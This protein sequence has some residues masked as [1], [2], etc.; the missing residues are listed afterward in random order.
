METGFRTRCV[1]SFMKRAVHRG[2]AQ[3]GRRWRP[4]D[5]TAAGAAS[6]HLE[7]G[8]ALVPL[9][10]AGRTSLHRATGR[11]VGTGHMWVGVTSTSAAWRHLGVGGSLVSSATSGRTLLHHA[12]GRV[13]AFGGRYSSRRC[14]APPGGSGTSVYFTTARGI[15]LCYWEGGGTFGAFLTTAVVHCCR[16][17]DGA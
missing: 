16:E 3:Q 12:A 2:I 5:I 7:G 1:G 9:T 4:A 14:L 8:G 15:A 6:R 11:A 17:G 13:M 10:T